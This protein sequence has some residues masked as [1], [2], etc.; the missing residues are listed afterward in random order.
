[1]ELTQLLEKCEPQEQAELK[2]LANAVTRNLREYNNDP[3]AINMKNW[4]TAKEVLDVEQKKLEKKYTPPPKAVMAWAEW[5]DTK[6][7]AEVL[8]QL[9]DLG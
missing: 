1:M 7:K 9:L 5:Q 6:N 2:I 4:Q 3:S 8:R